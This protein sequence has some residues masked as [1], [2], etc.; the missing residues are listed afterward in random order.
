MVRD[1]HAA[2]EMPVTFGA[3][4]ANLKERARCGSHA[5][6]IILVAGVRYVTCA[7]FVARVTHL[8]SSHGNCKFCEYVL[9]PFDV[10][11]EQI[12]SFDCVDLPFKNDV[13]TFQ[14]V[15]DNYLVLPK[16]FLESD[17]FR[18]PRTVR[19]IDPDCLEQGLNYR[20]YLPA[21]YVRLIFGIFIHL[22]NRYYQSMC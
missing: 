18:N 22:R 15:I 14:T 20:T 3:V 21:L 16:V 8:P 12:I 2:S 7:R 17:Q 10:V 6:A 9:V 1:T 4:L 11:I 5:V 13:F 19:Q